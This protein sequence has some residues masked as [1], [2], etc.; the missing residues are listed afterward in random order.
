MTCPI[1]VS[2]Q[3]SLVKRQ[4]LQP[5]LFGCVASA[6]CDI[7]AESLQSAR[8]SHKTCDERSLRAFSVFIP[9]LGTLHAVESAGRAVCN[10]AGASGSLLLCETEK[11]K[12]YAQAAFKNL[13]TG[14][15]GAWFCLKAA[16]R[17]ARGVN[18]LGVPEVVRVKED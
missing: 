3:Q 18:A 9:V 13:S 7:H 11:S 1:P 10:L 12:S 4:L 8:A 17:C 6:A 16:A 5:T 14:T 15:Q 2:V